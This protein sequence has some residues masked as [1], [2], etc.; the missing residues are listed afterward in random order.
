M[1]GAIEFL[2]KAKAICDSRDSCV[3][4]P[5]DDLCLCGI[6]NWDDDEADLVRKIMEY[7]LPTDEFDGKAER[8]QAMI[9]MFDIC[10]TCEDNQ[11]MDCVYI[12]N[13]DRKSCPKYRLEVGDGKLRQ[14]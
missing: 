4:C 14:L 5:V 1:T 8:N 7:Q 3:N 6:D 2:R 9:E 13:D 11:V 10:D 12:E